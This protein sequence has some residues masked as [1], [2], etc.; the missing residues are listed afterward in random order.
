MHED[1]LIRCAGTLVECLAYI[2]KQF[3][4]AEA[5]ALVTESAE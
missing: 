5:M 4:E 3:E 2:Q 1:N